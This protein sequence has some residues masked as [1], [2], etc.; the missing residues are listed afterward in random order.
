[1]GR[2]FH[3]GLFSHNH[4]NCHTVLWGMEQR[5]RQGVV[6]LAVVAAFKSNKGM[7]RRENMK[8]M[9]KVLAVLAGSTMLSLSLAGCSQ[10]APQTG[11][12]KQKRR[13]LMRVKPHLGEKKRSGY[14]PFLQALINGRRSGLK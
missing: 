2:R 7:K 13:L 3:D 1:M 12:R 10:S 11:G 8:K 5:K 9:K 14:L 6:F 4:R